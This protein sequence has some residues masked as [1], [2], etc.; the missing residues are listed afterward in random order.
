[1]EDYSQFMQQ[2]GSWTEELLL[3]GISQFTMKDVGVLEQFLEEIKRF[4]LTF[5]EEIVGLL[6]AE[7]RSLALGNGNEDLMLDHYCRLTQYVQLSIQETS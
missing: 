1:M 6:I 7:G 2:I 4:Q 5:L 3:R